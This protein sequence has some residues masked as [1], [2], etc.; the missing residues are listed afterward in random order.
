MGYTFLATLAILYFMKLV[1]Y[2]CRHYFTPDHTGWW[3]ATEFNEQ[4]LLED[5][6]QATDQ[7]TWTTPSHTNGHG[8]YPV[9]PDTEQLATQH[10]PPAEAL[11][12]PDAPAP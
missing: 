10:L 8:P 6:L 1:V 2:L 3:A 11:P 5:R 12:T 9:I 7:Q 4:Y